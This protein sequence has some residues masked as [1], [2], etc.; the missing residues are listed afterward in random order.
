MR[1]NENK[2]LSIKPRLL[3]KLGP[4]LTLLGSIG[5]NMFEKKKKLGHSIIHKEKLECEYL[6]LIRVSKF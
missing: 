1:V 5:L 3:V 2:N 4:L 6:L